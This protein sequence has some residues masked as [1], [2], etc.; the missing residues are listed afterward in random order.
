[1]SSVR[2]LV[3]AFG[4]GV[5]FWVL[6]SFTGA[7]LDPARAEPWTTSLMWSLLASVLIA[8][9][10]LMAYHHARKESPRREKAPEPALSSRGV[11]AD[12]APAFAQETPSLQ[13][14]PALEEGPA[15][16]QQTSLWPEPED[17]ETPS[18]SEEHRDWPQVREDTEQ[19]AAA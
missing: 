2:H 15:A 9:A 12:E 4:F 5:S 8:P 19:T 3:V 6:A 10:L 11:K 17:H 13:E 7:M 14:P 18:A 16:Q 1:M